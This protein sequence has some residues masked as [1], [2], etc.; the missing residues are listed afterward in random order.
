MPSL[1]D[2]YREV[3]RRL[4]E[5]IDQLAEDLLPR[6]RLEGRRW[7]RV[8]SLAGEEGQS[9]A[10]ELRGHKRGRWFDYAAGIGGDGLDLVAQVKFDGNK[11]AAFAWARDWLRMPERESSAQKAQKAPEHKSNNDSYARSIKRI[12]LEARRLERGDPVDRYL[13]KRGIELAQLGR[14][15]RALRYHPGLWNSQTRRRWPAMVAAI[16]T[17]DGAMTAVHC[18][19]LERDSFGVT[20]APIPDGGAKRTIGAY[21]GGCIPLWRGASNKAWSQMPE[22][23]VLMVGEGI[24]DTLS[25]V[26][27]RSAWR[28]VCAVALSSM[29]AL[30]LPAQVRTLV[31]LAQNDRYPAA[32]GSDAERLLRKVVK[33]WLDDGRE[34]RVVKPPIFVKD[35]N[36]LAVW[37][38][39]E[40]FEI[41]WAD[42]GKGEGDDR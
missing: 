13:Q 42:W 1:S 35:W 6:G 10:V 8:G 38:R 40:K 32:G 7:W 27:N 19:W 2:E 17:P 28:A 31:I 9:L 14:A 30:Q 5:R 34:V 11:R 26:L 24:E 21:A 3:A 33:R 22:G 23:E 4:N 20:K 18:T 12:W 39:A 37:C 41:A 36:E 29:M 16:V 15:P 25:G